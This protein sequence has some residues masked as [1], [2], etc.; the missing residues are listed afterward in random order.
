MEVKSTSS[1]VDVQYNSSHDVPAREQSN[2]SPSLPSTSGGGA[3]IVGIRTL[4]VDLAAEHLEAALLRNDSTLDQPTAQK[5]AK[6]LLERVIGNDSDSKDL[7]T[8]RVDTR[9]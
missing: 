2:A 7:Q 1:N 4:P 9:A 3:D 5:M 6:K 8:F